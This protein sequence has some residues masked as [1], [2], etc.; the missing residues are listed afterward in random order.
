MRSRSKHRTP[1]VV[2]DGFLPEELATGMR[3]DIE[4]HF[5]GPHRQS[6][7]HRVWNYLLVPQL[8]TYLRTALRR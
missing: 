5:A 7:A 8:Y 2:I 6:D 4:G 1:L 3:A